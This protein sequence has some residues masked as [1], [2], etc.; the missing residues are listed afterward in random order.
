MECPVN[1]PVTISLILEVLKIDES[2]K[3]FSRGV[4]ENAETNYQEEVL[5]CISSENSSCEFSVCETE[6]DVEIGAEANCGHRKVQGAEGFPS[7]RIGVERRDVLVAVIDQ[8][9]PHL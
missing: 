1:C 9:T 2:K 5:S 6:N 7:P 4:E 3:D 8:G